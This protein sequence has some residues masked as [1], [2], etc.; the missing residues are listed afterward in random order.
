MTLAGSPL[1]NHLWVA[2]DAV[3]GAIMRSNFIVRPRQV[4]SQQIEACQNVVVFSSTDKVD[5]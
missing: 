3:Q 5:T 2:L 1:H 4:G